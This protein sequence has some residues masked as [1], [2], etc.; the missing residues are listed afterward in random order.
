LYGSI[1]ATTLIELASE[2]NVILPPEFLLHEEGKT[3]TTNKLDGEV[4]DDDEVL[5]L[6]MKPRSLKD[7]FAIFDILPQ[8]VNDLPSLRRIMREM[9][10]DASLD[11]VIY[12]EV[13]TG[14]KT[15][16]IDHHQQQQQ[17]QEKY[18]TK[19]E[20]VQT[21]LD[22]MQDFETS[23]RNRYDEAVTSLN[24]NNDYNIRLP[25]IPR[26]LISI[27]RSGTIEQAMENVQ[28]AID[29]SRSS[30]YIVGVELGGN[31]TRNNFT[32]FES[33]FATARKA[34]LS[35][36]IHC[37]EV[38][39]SEDD[40]TTKNNN[41]LV[42]YQE[43]VSIIQFKPERLGHALLLSNSLMDKLIKDPIHIECCPTSNVMTLG[44]TTSSSQ[45][46]GGQRGN[47]LDGIKYHPQ[48]GQWIHHQYPISINTDDSGIFSTTLTKEYI[49]VMK[50]YSL[51]ESDL[52]RI[53]V[54]SVQH[55]FDPSE[56]IKKWLVTMVLDMFERLMG[57]PLDKLNA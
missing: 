38:P 52:T 27:D 31:P 22:V 44:L 49:L 51:S 15:L 18:C 56:E 57:R 13:R 17:Q 12:L 41:E 9:L 39:M 37:G 5:F 4:D 2:R 36:S 46:T 21:I 11:N 26:L 55:I 7:C 19:K 3:S 53:I 48:L 8:C 25:M 30:K 33:V 14:P 47:L 35:I 20:Y 6:N 40:E 34:G 42:A 1:R 43:A 24:N 23:D 32:M 16:L 50:G 54:N 29:M 28:L 45:D 10:E